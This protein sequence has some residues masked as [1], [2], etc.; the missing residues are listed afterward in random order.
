MRAFLPKGQEGALKEIRA[1]VRRT[2]RALTEARNQLKEE[3]PAIESRG[4]G[5]GGPRHPGLALHTTEV[6]PG[7][8]PGH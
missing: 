2:D 5:R 4:S 1:G 6:G 3:G 8:G 7:H